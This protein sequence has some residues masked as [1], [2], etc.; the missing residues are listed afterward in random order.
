MSHQIP[1]GGN[2][3]VGTT[4][5]NLSGIQFYNPTKDFPNSTL[6]GQHSQSSNSLNNNPS[7]NKFQSTK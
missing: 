4:N 1:S 3:K 5:P 2:G 7:L 6:L